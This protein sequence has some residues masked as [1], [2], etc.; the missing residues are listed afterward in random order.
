M[1]C[2]AED[3]KP[4]LAAIHRGDPG[5]T[6]HAMAVQSGPQDRSCSTHLCAETPR[7]SAAHGGVSRHKN[8]AG[9]KSPRISGASAKSHSLSNISKPGSAFNFAVRPQRNR[10]HKSSPAE[11]QSLRHPIYRHRRNVDSSSFCHA[12]PS[13]PCVDQA[14][15]TM[16]ADA[17]IAQMEQ[18]SRAR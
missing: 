16:D 14:W 15:E 8:A 3:S 6:M 10:L 18:R 12:V 1:C 4:R 7:I 13:P 5:L 9:S 11:K 2:F 17:V